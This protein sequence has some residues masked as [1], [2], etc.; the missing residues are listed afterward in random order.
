MQSRLET[1]QGL[2]STFPGNR[3]STY[4]VGTASRCTGL[5]SR[6]GY[7]QGH[8]SKAST[9][10]HDGL[11]RTWLRGFLSRHPTTSVSFAPAMDC[12]A[13]APEYG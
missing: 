12:H 5:S 6:I 7:I 10:G 1:A 2:P 9:R 13:N 11:G 4:D 3:D 8:G